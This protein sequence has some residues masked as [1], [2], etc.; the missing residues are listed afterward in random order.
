VIVHDRGTRAG[1]RLFPD[2]Q[3]QGRRVPDDVVLQCRR[4]ARAGPYSITLRLEDR[5]SGQVA[6]P[7]DKQVSALIFEITQPDRGA[8]LSF[9]DL[10]LACSTSPTH[11]NAVDRAR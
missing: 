3:A 7:I 10:K 9:V 4:E 8:Y 5:R 1:R 6:F 11:A 2:R